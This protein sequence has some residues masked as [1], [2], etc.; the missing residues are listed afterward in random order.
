MVDTTDEWITARTGIK[1]RRIAENGDATSDMA[2]PAALR[3]L[4]TAGLDPADVDVILL[5][6]A[7]PDML[8]PSTAC[9]VQSNLGARRAAAFDL[10]A[11]CSGFLYGLSIG[12]AFIESGQYRNA[13]VIGA[14]ALTKIIDWEDRNTCVLFGDGAGAVVLTPSEDDR[15]LL[16]INLF[17]DGDLSH[18]LYLPAGGSR[19]PT[20]PRTID[21]GLHYVRMEGR[22]VFKY[23]VKHMSRAMEISIEQAGVDPDEI[24]LFIPHQANLRIMEAFAKRL[25]VPGEKVFVNV[26]RYGNTSAASVPIAL[27]EAIRSGRCGPGTLVGLTVFGGGFTWASAV[28]RI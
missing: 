17:S 18:L 5:G 14:E 12:K 10:S 20:S 26:D 16:S 7:T 15:G 1:E 2:T 24:D 22:E 19:N 8:F 13:L 9:I 25:G 27:D 21:E 23:A 3:A 6:T 28:V 11:A 4:E